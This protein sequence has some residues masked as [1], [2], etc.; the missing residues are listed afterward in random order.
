MGSRE[1]K[2]VKVS[3]GNISEAQPL[4]LRNK[5]LRPAWKYP[6]GDLGKGVTLG[7]IYGLAVLT[8]DTAYVAFNKVERGQTKAGVLSAIA[9][10]TGAEKW[11]YSTESQDKGKF[12]GGPVLGDS[13]LYIA[14]DKGFVHAV[15]AADGT[16]I[17]KV[18]VAGKRF[19]SS[20]ALVGGVLYIG[21]M[22]DHLYAL[23]AANGSTKWEFA[24]G[25]AIT[26]QPLV[27]AGVVYVGSFDRNFYALDAVTGVQKWKFKGDGWFWNNPVTADG[28]IIFV[29]SLGESFYA[30]N[31]SDGQAKW[32]YTT[33]AA[34]RGAPVLVGTG[35]IYVVSEDGQVHILDTATGQV[36]KSGPALN[37]KSL[38]DPTWEGGYLYIHD[39][40]EKLHKI[41][42]PAS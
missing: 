18:P 36:R 30:L 24:A 42:A 33:G 29:G 16:L 19:W 25:G 32:T 13:V 3:V 27:S 21:S 12:F 31:A 40:N 8:T 22:D 37:A 39:M 5:S 34:V 2:F 20:P 10:D 1:G 17:W 15:K 41:A 38:G 28:S 6:T 26:S 7:A 9:K 4:D 14:D 23:D 35:L 11:S